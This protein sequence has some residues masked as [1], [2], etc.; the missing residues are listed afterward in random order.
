MFKV[1]I[2]NLKTFISTRIPVEFIGVEGS[3]FGM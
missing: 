1:R 2:E 3:K